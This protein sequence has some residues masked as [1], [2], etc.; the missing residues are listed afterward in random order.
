MLATGTGANRVRLFAIASILALSTTSAALAGILALPTATSNTETRGF[1]GLNWSF[2]NNGGAP[3]VVVGVARVKTESDGDSNGA[4]LS[5]HL[6]VSGGLSFGKV[7]LT[8]LT[9]ESDRMVEV[10]MGYGPDGA[11]GTVGVALPYF[12][13][14]VDFGLEGGLAG[15][16][17]INSLDE[18]TVPTNGLIPRFAV[19]GAPLPF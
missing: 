17:G 18:W 6:P 9:G 19:V 13:G 5:V 3:E 10:G 11:L 12:S 8:G 2:G 16:A 14:G 7:K 15:Y 1:V 4:K